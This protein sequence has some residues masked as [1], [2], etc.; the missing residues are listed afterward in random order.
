MS[1]RL[2][3]A[4]IAASS[5]LVH[6][7]LAVGAQGEAMSEL[8]Q[9]YLQKA[10]HGHQAEVL[11]GQLA[12]QK[13]SSDQ[14]KQYGAHM[15]QD[16]ERVSEDLQKLTSKE[17][18]PLPGELSMPHQQIQR[19]LSQLSGKDFD[20]AYMSFMVLDH[21]KEIGEWEQRA[22]TITD[23]RVKHWTARMLPI[24][25]E[26]LEQGRAIA[27]AI[28]VNGNDLAKVEEATSPSHY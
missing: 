4:V 16:H 8:E 20:K 19:L 6:T 22:K 24:L 26:H 18:G 28:G 9:S 7:T 3:V 25:K 11:L 5:V 15:I 13:A 23:P 2:L 12:L 27:A 10:T 21:M 14:V 1:C 17:D